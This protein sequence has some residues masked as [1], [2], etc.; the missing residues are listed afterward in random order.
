MLMLVVCELFMPSYPRHARFGRTPTHLAIVCGRLYNKEVPEQQERKGGGAPKRHAEHINQR[1]IVRRIKMTPQR[2]TAASLVTCS[3]IGVLIVTFTLP[4]GPIGLT[5]LLL[6]IFAL[7]AATTALY[8]AKYL[9][10]EVEQSP[11]SNHPA[12][13]AVNKPQ[14]VR[15][16]MYR[17]VANKTTQRHLHVVR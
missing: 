16:H 17:P 8:A 11:S 14:P 9:W 10:N 5:S 12:Y 15:T 7:A 4:Y 6:L 13:G 1:A 2:I 3:L